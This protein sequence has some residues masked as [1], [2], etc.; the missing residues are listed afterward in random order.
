MSF[1]GRA[2]KKEIPDRLS[3]IRK[4]V[5]TN[6][7]LTRNRTFGIQIDGSRR[8]TARAVLFKSDN[9]DLARDRNPTSDRQAVGD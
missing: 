4:E 7:D 6:C 1:G 9:S 5:L 8:A 2:N 3:L